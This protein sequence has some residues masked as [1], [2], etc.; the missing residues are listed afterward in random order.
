MD[1][2]L[3]RTFEDASKT[4]FV[5]DGKTEYGRIAEV[6][7]VFVLATFDDKSSKFSDRKN[8]VLWR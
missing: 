7:P 4:R 8:A 1:G 5:W 2:N 6:G 3:L